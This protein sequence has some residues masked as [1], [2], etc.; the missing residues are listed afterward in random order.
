MATR[1]SAVTTT[2]FCAFTSL[3]NATVD[4][5]EIL[6]LLRLVVFPI[7]YK[8]LVLYVPGGDRQISEPSTVARSTMLFT[9]KKTHS[10]FDD[11]FAQSRNW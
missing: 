9:D 7:I 4:G 1:N 6:R 5:S 3:K 2:W 11:C 8:G 10:R